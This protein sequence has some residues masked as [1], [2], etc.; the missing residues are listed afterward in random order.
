MIDLDIVRKSN[1]AYRVEAKP[2]GSQNHRIGVL[3]GK[4]SIRKC[5]MLHVKLLSFYAVN[6]M[7]Q[8]TFY[9]INSHRQVVVTMTRRRIEFPIY[10]GTI[11][12]SFVI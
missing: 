3:R 2:S 11:F 8:F 1:R 9:T 5:I 6:E 7:H 4:P 12:Q 10:N